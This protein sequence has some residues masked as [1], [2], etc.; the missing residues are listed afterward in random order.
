MTETVVWRG[1]MILAGKTVPGELYV[2][3]NADGTK[4]W[5]WRRIGG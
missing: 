3:V 5:G 2:T 1:L 4:G